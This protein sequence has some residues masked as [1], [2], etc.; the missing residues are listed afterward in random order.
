MSDYDAVFYYASGET[1]DFP[2]QAADFYEGLVA[3]GAGGGA[4]SLGDLTPVPASLPTFGPR[5]A[6]GSIR[7]SS[8][9]GDSGEDSKMPVHLGML[10]EILEARDS[11]RVNRIHIGPS[12]GSSLTDDGGPGAGDS[13]M[14]LGKDTASR[15]LLILQATLLSLLILMSFLWALCCKKRCIGSTPL[16]TGLTTRVAE[17]ARKISTVSRD[18][19]PPSYSRCDLRSIGLTINDHFN[20]PPSY[21]TAANLE[22]AANANN[23]EYIANAYNNPSDLTRNC[24]SSS[25][26]TIWETGGSPPSSPLPPR[27]HSADP[28]LQT[29]SGPSPKTSIFYALPRSLASSSSAI[30]S[31]SAAGG[32]GKV[33]KAK[34]KST[35]SLPPPRWSTASLPP[36]ILVNGLSSLSSPSSPEDNR[37]KRSV[38]SGNKSRRVSFVDI[39]NS[40]GNK[41]R[42]VSFVDEVTGHS[43][44]RLDLE[45]QEKIMRKL[46]E[47]M[48]NGE[49][50]EF[51]VREIDETKIAE[52]EESEEKE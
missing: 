35:A 38:P 28:T 39:V 47:A 9:G 7:G 1:A 5:S 4:S 18:S 29:P 31:K 23:G 14:M 2:P 20:P 6:D 41:S 33:Q 50:A 45:G 30:F 26:V 13:P 34:R 22:S 12:D 37:R 40:A 51:V 17:F 43:M 8:N 10:W 36:S 25:I 48:R 49:L 24:S 52:S 46:S 15:D 27:P 19:L 16:S 44:G 11:A 21:E 3:A 42:K 32:G